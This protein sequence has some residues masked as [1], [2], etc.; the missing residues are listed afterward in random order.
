MS[1]RQIMVNWRGDKYPDQLNNHVA[2]GVRIRKMYQNDG[3]FDFSL[4]FQS[5]RQTYFHIRVVLGD[6]QN[7][8][9]GERKKGEE[10]RE[11]MERHCE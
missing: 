6:Y 11:E 5:D 3:W 1:I 2:N 10:E 7:R 8:N 9:E 4:T